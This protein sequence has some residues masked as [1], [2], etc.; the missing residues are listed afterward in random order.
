MD[1]SD[2]AFLIPK[3]SKGSAEV[4]GRLI[5]KELSEEQRAHYAAEGSGELAVKSYEI[6][7]DAVKIIGS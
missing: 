7:A 3:D 6:I 2:H 5:E 1:F 4:Y